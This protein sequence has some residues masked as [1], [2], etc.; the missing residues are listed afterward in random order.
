MLLLLL[1]SAR[2]LKHLAPPASREGEARA[3][4]GGSVH[5]PHL[6][7]GKGR[8][9]NNLHS[10]SRLASAPHRS[11]IPRPPWLG[12]PPRRTHMCTLG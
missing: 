8:Q 5:I 3:A 9:S 6:S 12:Q 2:K 11:G 4:S 7:P 1:V 10:A